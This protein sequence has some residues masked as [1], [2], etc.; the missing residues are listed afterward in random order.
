[1]SGAS[2]GGDIP[3]IY[4]TNL[5]PVW[6]QKYAIDMAATMAESE[7]RQVLEIACGTG[8]VTKA[9]RSAL[10]PGAKLVATDLSADMLAVAQEKFT[11][12][13][14]V[15]LKQADGTALPFSDDMFDAVVCQFGMMF[16]PDK[17]KGLREAYRV[18]A[19][20]GR[21]L[22]SVWDNR[23]FNPLGRV[24]DETIA[25][26]FASDPP[27]FYQIPFSYARV[28]EIRVS[29]QEVGFRRIDIAIIPYDHAIDDLRPL[30][31][32]VVFGSPL[33]AQVRDRGGDHQ[34]VE[35]TVLAALRCEFGGEPTTIPH[36]AIMIVASKP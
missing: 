18:L 2:F 32:G 3:R 22:F 5:G 19:P 4:D 7:P 13:D 33:F 28:D 21:Y 29:L 30:A 10:S 16:Y 31:H 12:N 23:R 14:G 27:K 35:Q 15:E 8:I 20:G 11:P 6:F 24:L 9:L 25:G 26:M 1:M 34:E 17:E 36:Q